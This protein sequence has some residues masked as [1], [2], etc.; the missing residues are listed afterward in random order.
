MRRS[1]LLI[2]LTFAALLGVPSAASD[3]AVSEDQA[4]NICRGQW[5]I[6]MDSG[7]KICADCIKTPAG[8]PFCNF[9]VCDAA[10]CEWIVVAKTKPKAPWKIQQPKLP[11]NLKTDATKK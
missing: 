8:T 9:F 10:G 5:V 7:T 3:L 2:V 11:K 1:R 4:R 6:N